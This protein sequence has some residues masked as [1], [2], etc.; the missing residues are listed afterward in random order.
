[1]FYTTFPRTLMQVT[2]EYSQNKSQSVILM[3]DSWLTTFLC[4]R[5]DYD[6]IKYLIV[7]NCIIRY[8]TVLFP[9]WGLII[10][11]TLW[12]FLS[13]V[14]VSAEPSCRIKSLFSILK[15]VPTLSYYMQMEFPS[16]L[17]VGTGTFLQF[18][19]FLI[20][21]PCSLIPRRTT[22]ALMFNKTSCQ[23]SARS[24]G[25]LEVTSLTRQTKQNKIVIV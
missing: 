18:F 24:E 22:E 25:L 3:P 6:T 10:S 21:L 4:R 15:C 8:K 19:Q 14:I 7:Q 2:S 9:S 17:L 20:I 5:S 12:P 16:A 11:L 13:D 1:M 23:I